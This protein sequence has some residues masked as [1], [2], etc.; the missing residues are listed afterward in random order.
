MT[1]TSADHLH[2][3]SPRRSG[4]VDV[5]GQG[6]EAA[7]GCCDPF[8]Y[9]Q[10]VL[11]RSRQAVELPDDKGGAFAQVVEHTVQFWSVPASTRR[12]FLEDTAASGGS[13]CLGLQGVG[14]LIALGYA[15]ITKQQA[16]AGL[17]RIFHKRTF[18]DGFSGHGEASRFCFQYPVAELCR[19][20][21]CL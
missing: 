15:S 16:A 2:H 5:F 10:H 18:A 21:T 14:L 8:H 4:G 1:C 20:A 11:Q 9:V 19:K 3:H 13:K 17:P 12:R 6:A 7:S